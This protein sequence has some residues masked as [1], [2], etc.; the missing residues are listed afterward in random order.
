MNFVKNHYGF[1]ELVLWSWVWSVGSYELCEFRNP[2]YISF[3]PRENVPQ[4]SILHFPFSIYMNRGNE[5]RMSQ[6]KLQTCTESARVLRNGARGGRVLKNFMRS[7]ASRTVTHRGNK[8]RMS[9]NQS[10]LSERKREQGS[11]GSALRSK[12]SSAVTHHFQFT[13]R[14]IYEL[15]RKNTWI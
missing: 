14:Y 10:E 12:A 11:A 15:W 7:K 6:K 1:G 3:S 13:R 4:F 2:F 8:N 9:Q 5:S